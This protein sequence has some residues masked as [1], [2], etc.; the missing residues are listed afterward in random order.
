MGDITGANATYMLSIT[1][2]FPAPIQL[3]GFA[4]DDVFDTDPLESA[5]VLMGVDGFLSAGFV[6]VAVKQSVTLQADSNSNL[7]FDVWWTA[8]QSTRSNFFA[9]GVVLLP[10]INTQWA[11]I[12]GALT[13]YPPTPNV[14]KLLQPRKYGIT[15][16]GIS[17]AV[18]T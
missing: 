9:N 3:Q 12:N 8:N 4:A 6:F 17:P 5:E 15:W 16:G 1:D 14:K 7:I 18:V 13:S 11:M 2:L 10:A